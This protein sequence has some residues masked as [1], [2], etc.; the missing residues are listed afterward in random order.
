MRR[1][2]GK[3]WTLEVALCVG[4]GVAPVCLDV[5]PRRLSRVA[6]VSD[7]SGRWL[8]EPWVRRADVVAMFPASGVLWLLKSFRT[9]I[10]CPRSG[11]IP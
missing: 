8:C 2:C 1:W 6:A 5:K 9:G 3:A 11:A 10:V 4:L 7:P